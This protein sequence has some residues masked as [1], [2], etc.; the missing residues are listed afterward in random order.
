MV[1]SLR[2]SAAAPEG[3]EGTMMTQPAILKGRLAQLLAMPRSEMRDRI[4]WERFHVT[5]E[6]EPADYC[7]PV[8][9]VADDDRTLEA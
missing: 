5:V 2:A 8:D 7:T 3:S 6:E 9:E 1:S 4:L